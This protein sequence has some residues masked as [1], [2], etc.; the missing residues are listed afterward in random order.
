MAN[1]LTKARKRRLPEGDFSTRDEV[2]PGMGFYP[3]SIN[4]L[5]AKET[6]ATG[7]L[8]SEPPRSRAAGC[9]T[10]ALTAMALMVR[11]PSTS[12]AIDR[13]VVVTVAVHMASPF[14][15]S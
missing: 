1:F 8:Y 2:E 3:C 5:P 12:S 9:C 11:M 4:N 7:R 14:F 13:I 15:K 10:Q 6:Y